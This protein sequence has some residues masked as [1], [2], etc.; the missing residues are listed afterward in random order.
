MKLYVP[1]T[2]LP[3]PLRGVAGYLE[4]C[5]TLDAYP[6]RVT[7]GALAN[8]RHGILIFMLFLTRYGPSRSGMERTVSSR[9]IVQVNGDLFARPFPTSASMSVDLDQGN[10][11]AVGSSYVRSFTL[12]EYKMV[13]VLSCDSSAC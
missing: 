4:K 8:I 13:M 2:F 11:G 9:G 10:E 7:E 3:L 6:K 5:K 12:V 1:F